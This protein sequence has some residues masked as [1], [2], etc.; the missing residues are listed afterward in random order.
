MAT[1]GKMDCLGS[2][3]VG[4]NQKRSIFLAIELPENGRLVQSK[5]QFDEIANRKIEAEQISTHLQLPQGFKSKVRLKM[6][7]V[8]ALFVGGLLL[9]RFSPIP[10]DAELV[11]IAVMVVLS[12]LPYFIRCERCHYPL[13]SLRPERILGHWRAFFL[14]K[15]C[16]K[17]GLEC[18]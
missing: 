7:A 6:L 9:L 13:I 8:F 11:V 3:F 12:I 16:P 2:G 5:E 18:L 15:H 17:C 4:P 1:A 10:K 14:P